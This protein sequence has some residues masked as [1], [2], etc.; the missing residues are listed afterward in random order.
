MERLPHR[1]HICIQKAGSTYLYNLLRSHPDISLS[2]ETEVDFYTKHFDRGE[3]W[4]SGTFRKDGERIDTS[5][6]TFM[7][8]SVA[9]PR[10]E[11]LVPHAKCLLILRNPISYVSSH[12][13]MHIQQGFFK[14]HPEQYPDVSEHLMTFLERYPA[15]L[16]W[17]FFAR[18]LKEHWLFRLSIDQFKI[19]TFERFIQETESVMN[20]ILDFWDI[21]RH[22]LKANTLS[23]NRALRY[24]WL[25]KV[26]TFV[27]RR[28]SLKRALKDSR[29]F[30]SVMRRFLTV[31]TQPALSADDRIILA[32]KLKDD[33]ELLRTITGQSFY[34]WEDFR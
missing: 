4:Y 19:I 8:G 11:T 18:T 1:I 3:E 9:A 33:V 21:P 12:F 24:E 13:H 22:S 2:S 15:Y 25:H 20:E 26:R 10:I 31:D 16:D 29:F 32:S 28:E 14:R 5:P 23:Q 7:L 34:E 27:V 6:K 17:A 30:H